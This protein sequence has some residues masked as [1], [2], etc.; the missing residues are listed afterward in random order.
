MGDTGI[1]FVI[2]LQEAQQGQKQEKSHRIFLTKPVLKSFYLP[3][4]GLDME[5]FFNSLTRCDHGV[6]NL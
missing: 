1:V 3:L 6:T 2:D 4:C 5:G